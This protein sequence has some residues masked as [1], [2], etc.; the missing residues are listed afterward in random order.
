MAAISVHSYGNVWIFP[1]G[2]TEEQHPEK[3]RISKLAYKVVNTIRFMTG[4]IFVPGTAYEV[5]F[6]YFL[7]FL[8]YMWRCLASGG[9]QVAVQMTGIFLWVFLTASLLSCLRGMQ[10][11][12]MAFFY[13]LTTLKG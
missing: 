2:Y 4:E 8:S 11:D 6:T 1:W 7:K 12:S 9:L 13:L 5:S 10:M 3:A